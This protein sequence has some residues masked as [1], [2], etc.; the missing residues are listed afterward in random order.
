MSH[1]KF[2][3]VFALLV[4]LCILSAFVFPRSTSGIRAHVQG[5][6]YPVAKPA[7]AIA[8][9]VRG[10]LDRI[11]DKRPAGDIAAENQRLKGVV[12]SLSAQV[13]HL[14]SRVAEGEQFGEVGKDA[15]R[16]AVMGNDP[17]SRDSLSVVGRFDATLFNQPALYSYG[18]AGRFERAGLTGAQVRLIT[19]RSF[20]VTGRFA[21]FVD[22]GQGGMVWRE[23]ET[24][25]AIVAGAGNGVMMITNLEYKEAVEDAKIGEGTWVVLADRE[26]PPM[27][28]NQKLGRVVSVRR[29]AE[30]ALWADIEVRPEWNLMALTQVWVLR[31]PNDST[32][33]T[34]AN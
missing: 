20:S 14:S 21:R 12:A 15:K 29:Q 9:S 3:H 19:D 13:E 30:A 22:N 11:D 34:R 7:R 6:F 17:Q 8:S 1:V 16:I 26:Y 25:P 5:M 23:L 28:Q 10:S 31:D 33:V 2:N 18:L 24:K 32:A 4:L 27:L